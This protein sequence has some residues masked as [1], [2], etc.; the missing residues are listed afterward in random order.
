MTA[1]KHLVLD[2]LDRP[3][4]F[5]R[6]FAKLAGSVHAGLMLSQAIYWSGRTSDGSGWFYKT[7]RDWMQETFLTRAEQET[8]RRQLKR[9]GDFWHEKREGVPARLS[10]MVCDGVI[11]AIRLGR[12]LRFNSLQLRLLWGTK[13]GESEK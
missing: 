12:V 9:A 6:C 2:L 4:A 1:S 13:E 8:A 3:I 7:R 10:K 11:P 5:H